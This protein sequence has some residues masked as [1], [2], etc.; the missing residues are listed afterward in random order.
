MAG[1][2]KHV[3]VAADGTVWGVN[4]ADKIYRWTGSA[5][6]QV[7]GALS[8]ISAGSA[9]QVWGVNSDGKIYQRTGT[10]WTQV[11][12]ALKHV[13]VAADG[14]VWGVNAAG[15]NPPIALAPRP[16][17]RVLRLQVRYALGLRRRL[18]DARAPEV[19]GS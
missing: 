14:T 7:A 12:G 15:N 10:S 5:W 2:L 11:P 19:A 1:A 6:E 17:Q 13:S 16:G 18:H 4:A 8:Q 9:A 3:S